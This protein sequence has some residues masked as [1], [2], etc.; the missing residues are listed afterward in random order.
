[1]YVEN[2]SLLYM[3]VFLTFVM[4]G[5]SSAPQIVHCEARPTTIASGSAAFLTAAVKDPASLTLVW[6]Q[7][8]PDIP[9][10]DLTSPTTLW[11]D[12]LTPSVAAKTKYRIQM[13]VT[14]AQGRSSTC[15]VVVTV[16]KKAENP[17]TWG[18]VLRLISTTSSQHLGIQR[19]QES[20]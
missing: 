10:G 7:L 8:T 20:N 17:R 6:S 11:T 13:Q 1:M 16:E 9:R 2:Q 19:A 14:N 15:K 5:C 4:T 12:F 18:E 3:A